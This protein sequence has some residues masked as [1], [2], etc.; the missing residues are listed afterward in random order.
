[1]SFVSCLRIT[2]RAPLRKSTAFG[3]LEV[4]PT[5]TLPAAI[6]PH[7]IALSVEDAAR[8]VGGFSRRFMFMEM[9]AGRLRSK[10][11]G[12]RR[13]IPVEALQAWWTARGEG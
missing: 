4:Q 9:E 13:V 8:A 5:N 3:A 1:V 2:V 7:V 10:K 11:I 6:Q 12:R